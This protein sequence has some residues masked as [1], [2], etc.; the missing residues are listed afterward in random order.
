M[1]KFSILTA[2][3]VCLFLWVPIVA[4]EVKNPD[5]FVLADIGSVETLDPAKAYDNA[6]AAKLYTIYENLIFFKDPHTDQFSPGGVGLRQDHH[7]QGHYPA[8]RSHRRPGRLL[9]AG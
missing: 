5:T 2:L 6:G 4:A 3:L 8:A 1:K 7:R 9:S